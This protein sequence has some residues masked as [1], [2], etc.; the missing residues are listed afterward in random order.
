MCPK[1]LARGLSSPHLG[2]HDIQTEDFMV[3]AWQ[4]KVFKP[5]NLP[6]GWRMLA[7][8]GSVPLYTS[9]PMIGQI[10]SLTNQIPLTF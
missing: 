8:K 7:W 6:L 10:W 2:A 4:P 3:Q 5:R 1:T 9:S